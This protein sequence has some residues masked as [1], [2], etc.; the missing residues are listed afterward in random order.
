MMAEMASPAAIE[1]LVLGFAFDSIS[2]INWS[3]GVTTGCR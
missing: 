3:V 1:A 2:D